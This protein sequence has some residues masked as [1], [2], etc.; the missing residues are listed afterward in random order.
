M[1]V[2]RLDHSQI[3]ESNSA[4]LRI[5]ELAWKNDDIFPVRLGKYVYMVVL[6]NGG[7]GK[8]LEA[9][10]RMGRTRCF[11]LVS[12]QVCTRMFFL[13]FVS[14]CR[15]GLEQGMIYDESIASKC[16]LSFG[17]FLYVNKVE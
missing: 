11:T 14:E 17:N 16:G 4:W 2:V 15:M 8:I 5:K 13:S 1:E 6:S 3:L 9:Y 10:N 12:D 7:L